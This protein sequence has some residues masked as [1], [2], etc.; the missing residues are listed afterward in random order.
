M[1]AEPLAVE[2]YPALYQALV[3]R[4]HAVG[5]FFPLP[6]GDAAAWGRRAQDVDTLWAGEPGERRR[7]VLAAAL[8]A[9]ADRFGRTPRQAANL[10][11]LG[12]AG[13]LV[14]V[15]GQQAGLLA[16]PLYTAYKALGAVL[17]AEQAAAALRRPVVPV[18]WVASED[19]DWS[20]ISQLGVVSPRGEALQLRFSGHGEGRSAGHQPVPPEA[21]HL[22]GQLE[23]VFPPSADGATVLERLR[24]GLQRW[25]RGSLADWFCAQLQEL[26][27]DTGLLL[28]DPMLPELR[29]LAAPTLAEAGAR[30]PL[31]HQAL[32]ERAAVLRAQGFV[33]GLQVDPDHTLLFTYLDRHRVGLHRAGER[34]RSADGRV[35][36]SLAELA[37]E[38][39]R[40]PHDF[41]PNVVLRPV[42][43]D[44][45]L[46]VLE[47]LAG[48]G[49]VAYLAQLGP[50]FA[51][52]ERP[53]PIVSPRPGGTV[54]TPEDRQALTAAGAEIAELLRDAEA[55][56]ERAARAVA[57]LDLEALFAD[58]RAAW[59]ARYL[60]L[61]E[62]LARIGPAMPAIVRRNAQH[63]RHQLDYLE[64]KARQHRRR[65]AR[66]VVG[67][68]RA[69]SGRLFPGGGLQERHQSVYAYVLREG[70]QWL[71]DLRE[72]MAAA[73]GP[74][75][76]HWL[77]HREE[78]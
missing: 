35:D 12:Q 3:E 75:G 77:F 27:G 69:A 17:R 68:L 13:T 43:Q 78:G 9:L 53:Q 24:A 57:P 49:E 41:S 73:P 60:H 7:Q 44:A 58:E 34:V 64:A 11:A 21:R 62:T 22:I 8:G 2:V 36:L 29:A 66:A 16:G 74:F 72:A 76:R 10:E 18:F 48:P 40:R 1:R 45:T 51:L 14:V 28:Y 54:V 19:H 15:T 46:P 55:A 33:P 26:L 23:A 39:V 47:Q 65:A 30:A 25:G 42:V 5:E 20:E 70:P 71:G 52:W 59:E 56:V 6:P 31:A 50:V 37:Q 61:E 63:V 4:P 67:A 38:V 32:G